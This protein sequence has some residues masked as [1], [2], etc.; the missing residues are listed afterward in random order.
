MCLFS[1]IY[2]VQNL[3][4][5]QLIKIDGKIVWPPRG[6]YGFGYDAIFLPDGLN[7]TFGEL[8][9]SEKHSWAIDKVGLSHRAIAFSKFAKFLTKK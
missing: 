7:K 2:F 3:N 9:S 5:N 8:T 6:K 1:Q 4:P